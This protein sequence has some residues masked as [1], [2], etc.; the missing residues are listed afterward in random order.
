MNA[1]ETTTETPYTGPRPVH[2]AYDPADLYRYLTANT[3]PDAE[4]SEI[5]SVFERQFHLLP[6]HTRQEIR[7]EHI[8][9]HPDTDLNTIESFVATYTTHYTD[10]NALPPLGR[11]YTTVT[12]VDQPTPYQYRTTGTTDTP[13]IPTPS[14]GEVP[15]MPGEA[16]NTPL[17][18]EIANAGYRTGK[19]LTEITRSVLHKIGVKNTDTTTHETEITIEK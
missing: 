19:A 7:L 17:F 13:V 11:E 3:T 10:R 18:S 1:R 12:A 5:I 16:V 14:R 9:Q 2:L 15:V 4:L 6:Q 8:T